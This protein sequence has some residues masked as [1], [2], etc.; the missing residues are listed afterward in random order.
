MASFDLTWE[1]KPG[2]LWAFWG[3]MGV[4]GESFPIVPYMSCL[5]LRKLVTFLGK[6]RL[7]TVVM[8]LLSS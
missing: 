1:R 2:F 5:G 6:L 4:L 3:R 8:D 7:G